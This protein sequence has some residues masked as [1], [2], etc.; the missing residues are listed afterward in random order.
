MP[1]QKDLLKQMINHIVYDREDEAKATF[2]DFVAAKTQN[3]M[4]TAETS[5]EE[6]TTGTDDTSDIDGTDDTGTDDAGEG[7]DDT[8]SDDT[9]TETCEE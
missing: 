9:S 5:T 1:E 8:S 2:H 7:S 6:D 3:I 4:G